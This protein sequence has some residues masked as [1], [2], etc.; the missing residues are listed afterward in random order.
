MLDMSQVRLGKGPHPA[1]TNPTGN[2]DMC[3][4][5]AVSYFTGESWSHR[6][7]CVSPAIALFLSTWQDA[8]DDEERDLLFPPDKWI[9]ALV[10]TRG[11]WV[12]EQRRCHSALDWAIRIYPQIWFRHN[13]ALAP[14]GKALEKLPEISDDISAKK[15][16]KAIRAAC[17]AASRA[18]EQCSWNREGN[19]DRSE[20]YSWVAKTGWKS[21]YVVGNAFARKTVENATIKNSEK[22][23]DI[24]D[25]SWG[26]LIAIGTVNKDKFENC[27]QESRHG[28]IE[29]VKKMMSI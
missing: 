6:P 9:P 3:L 19:F 24:L 18:A 20:A 10:G 26:G 5:E 22:M 14:Y 25:L 13:L 29:I 27:L 21:A 11:D 28:A 23:A 15:A 17:F 1:Q 2:R 12:A 4:L 8:L 16:S 7:A